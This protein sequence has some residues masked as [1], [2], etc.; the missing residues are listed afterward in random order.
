MG[1]GIAEK[2]HETR[3]DRLQI[4]ILTHFKMTE[5]V[6]K[7]LSQRVKIGICGLHY[8]PSDP[9]LFCGFFSDPYSHFKISNFLF[10]K[11]NKSEPFSN[12]M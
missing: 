1:I 9:F 5:H 4:P 8:H 6:T 2:S 12:Y 10:M 11:Y 7:D 3:R